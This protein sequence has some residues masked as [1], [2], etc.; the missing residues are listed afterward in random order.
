MVFLQNI[1]TRAGEFVL[2]RQ[3]NGIHRQGEIINMDRV[4][5]IGIIYRA[6]NTEDE[7]NVMKYSEI[8][9]G[10]G[11][12]VTTLGFF[13]AK[14]PAK[15]INE[16]ADR[17]YFAIKDTNWYFKPFSSYFET[18]MNEDFDLLLDFDIYWQLSLLFICSQSAA[19]C[20]VGRYSEKFARMF[21]VMIETE[22][23]KNLEYFIKNTDTYLQMLNKPI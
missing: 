23:N 22:D 1:R 19:K 7:E 14:E 8:L 6:D 11:K 20:K 4:K 9:R 18:F 15:N 2:L 12:N 21:D 17:Q 10:R 3:Y 13:N 16:S 5:K